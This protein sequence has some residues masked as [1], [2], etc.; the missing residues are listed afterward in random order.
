MEQLQKNSQG[1]DRRKIFRFGVVATAFILLAGGYFM[2]G[3]FSAKVQYAQSSA[4]TALAG[5]SAAVTETERGLSVAVTSQEPLVLT[6]DRTIV[7]RFSPGTKAEVSWERLSPLDGLNLELTAGRLWVNT[8]NHTTS[9]NVTAGPMVS[10][11]FEPGVVDLQ[12]GEGK[13]L[14]ASVRHDARAT[15]ANKT[16]LVPQDRQL[17]LLLAKIQRSQKEL[18]QLHYDKLIKEFPLDVLDKS[19][20]WTSY[21]TREDEA[22]AQKVRLSFADHVRT[23]GPR[24]PLSGENL[25]SSFEGVLKSISLSLTFDGKKR[26]ERST[27]TIFDYLDT[28][29][30]A[31]VVG[32]QRAADLFL[33]RFNQEA[34]AAGVAPSDPLMASYRARLAFAQPRDAFFK[35]REAVRK[36]SADT[37]IKKL[38]RLFNDV[39]DA[40]VSDPA[41][42]RNEQMTLGMRRLTQAIDG[43]F[44]SSLGQADAE[45]LLLFST[46]YMSLLRNQ[47]MLITEEFLTVNEKLQEVHLNFLSRA[48][49]VDRQQ[50][51]VSEKLS[52]IKF[53]KAQLEAEKIDFQPTRRA[54]LYLVSRIDAVRPVFSEAAYLTYVDSQLMQ[55]ADFIAFVRS[56]EG[57]QA[58]GSFTEELDV[59]KKAVEEAQKIRELLSSADGG[60]AIS[61]FRR[62]E[63]AAEV[64]K[65]LYGIGLKDIKVQL[66]DSEQNPVV[67][68]VTA[69]FESATF[70]AN[71]DTNR[72]LFS[73]V[74]FRGQEVGNSI[75][76]ENLKT[77]MLVTLG[78]LVLK[79]GKTTETLVEQDAQSDFERVAHITLAN[80]LARVG[81]K[82]EEQYLDLS[83]LASDVI[84]IRLARLGEGESTRLFSFDIDSK[85]SRVSRL[86]IQTVAGPIPVNDTFSLA[87]LPNRVEQVY[88]RALFE[89]EKDDEVKRLLQGT[90][91]A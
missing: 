15:F 89:K 5:E 6:L 33:N 64:S 50:Y 10:A 74:V 13:L 48:D 80:A 51:F 70:S 53:L 17:S 27:Q 66:P 82:V 46:R 59:Y 28:A 4:L 44:L 81:V 62:E 21:N 63:L 18:A 88:Q 11:L 84:H 39:L 79:D 38:G 19:D 25:L 45:E 22:H 86:E 77:Y 91:G 52:L 3:F 65:D 32:N 2:D 35:A 14:I 37:S 31:L 85:A 61:P 23:S 9:T 20:P 68:I 1:P 49:A 69:K 36:L 7:L 8:Q 42:E 67:R 43:S 71:Y 73:E 26:L 90:P 40:A 30:Y 57:E 47:P 54:L 29:L 24:F 76:L 16:I 58:N 83:D 60:G 75:R 55:L 72:K 56:P 12:L 78:K 34:T 41:T 87:E